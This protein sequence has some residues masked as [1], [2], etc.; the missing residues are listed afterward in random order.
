MKIWSKVRPNLD[1]VLSIKNNLNFYKSYDLRISGTFIVLRFNGLWIMM[2]HSDFEGLD[3]FLSSLQG[4][5]NILGDDLAAISFQ[6]NRTVTTHRP[7]V[8]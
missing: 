4:L 6:I 1:T 3:S 8:Q 2:N 7:I 5:L